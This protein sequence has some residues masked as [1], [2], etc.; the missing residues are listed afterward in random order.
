MK[1]KRSLHLKYPPSEPCG[2]DVCRGYCARPGWW[3]VEQAKN[4]VADGL[5]GRMM[6]EVSPE[7]DFGV[8]SPAFV[9]CEGG[10]AL[11]GFAK[12]G[13]NF[14]KDGLC[15]L[16]A[17]GHLPLECAYCHHARAG[18]GKDCHDDLERDW[19]TE[20]GKQLVNKWLKN[21]GIDRR[22]LFIDA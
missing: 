2:C 14:F 16:H 11:Q 17:T 6:V 21:I 3:T 13:C 15:E 12:N 9:G 20:Q 1:R 22:A 8:L 4:A 5:S 7:R 18:L 19:K 10:I